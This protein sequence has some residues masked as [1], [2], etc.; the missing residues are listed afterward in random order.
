MANFPE[1]FLAQA[2][3]SGSVELCVSSNIVVCMRMKRL[4][5]LAA[6]FFLRL[7]FAVDVYGPRIPV[8][9]FAANVVAALENQN[10]L[11]CRGQ[12]IGKG[13][14]ACA[15]SDDDHVIVAIRGHMFSPFSSKISF[16]GVQ[17]I[18]SERCNALSCCDGAWRNTPPA[19]NGLAG[20]VRRRPALR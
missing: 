8:G 18:G 6:P 4:S 15:G 10:A 14:T 20:T 1:V 2:E 16:L 19:R 3:E 17:C 11:S 5:V 7:I 13:A 12:G 9:F